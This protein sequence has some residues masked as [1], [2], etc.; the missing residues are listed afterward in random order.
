MHVV[1]R[2]RP[3]ALDER[4][5]IRR[6]SVPHP[7]GREWVAPGVSEQG[8]AVPK[9][10]ELTLRGDASPALLATFFDLDLT[11]RAGRSERRGVVPDQA[12]LE[13]LLD[14]L[15]GLGLELVD[16]R[17]RPEVGGDSVQI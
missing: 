13:G 10:V 6:S 17:V 15:F 7:G 2:V 5:L 12:A 3:G 11:A 16:L 8:G 14:R 1:V 4:T 9:T